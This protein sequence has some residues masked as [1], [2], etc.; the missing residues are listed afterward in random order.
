MKIQGL[1]VLIFTFAAIALGVYI[2]WA[3]AGG[4]SFAFGG[5]Y[6]PKWAPIPVA[7]VLA[8]IFGGIFFASRRKRS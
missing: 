5:T 2:L 8:I 6:L 1:I 4:Q 7:A 3:V